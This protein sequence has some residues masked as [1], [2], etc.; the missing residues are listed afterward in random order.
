MP[1]MTWSLT[2]SSFIHVHLPPASGVPALTLALQ[3]RPDSPKN[4]GAA[5][6][7][8]DSSSIRYWS[9]SPLWGCWTHS[10]PEAPRN[11]ILFWFYFIINKPICWTTKNMAA[12]YLHISYKPF[13]ISVFS[14]WKIKRG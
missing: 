11:L 7:G 10:C 6:H 5:V 3:Q 9:F 14:V 4:V 13:F 2:P 8:S 12:S 1:F